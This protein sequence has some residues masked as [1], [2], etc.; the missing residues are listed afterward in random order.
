[1]QFIFLELNAM[2]DH[3][4]MESYLFKNTVITIEITQFEKIT[5]THWKWYNFPESPEESYSTKPPV[6]LLLKMF[7][8]SFI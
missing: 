1:M 2:L 5:F 4:Q 6:E 7:S 3:V 8:S